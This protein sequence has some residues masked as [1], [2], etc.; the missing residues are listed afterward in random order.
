MREGGDVLF[1][2]EMGD[3]LLEREVGDI[4]FEREMRNVLSYKECT[5]YCCAREWKL[6]AHRSTQ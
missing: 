5:M 6:M 3:L 2:S 4:M 1:E